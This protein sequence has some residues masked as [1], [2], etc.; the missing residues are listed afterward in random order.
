MKKDG[1][2]R[3]F[4]RW[5]PGYRPSYMGL[6]PADTRVDPELFP[7]NEFPVV[8]PKCDYLL[9]GLP[10][11]TCPECG[12]SFDRGRLLVEQYVIKHG[13]QHAGKLK[14]HFTVLLP[15]GIILYLLAK[16]CFFLWHWLWSKNITLVAIPPRPPLFAFFILLAAGQVCLVLYLVMDLRRVRR[17]RKKVKLVSEAIDKSLPGFQ[18]A[19]RTTK[20]LKVLSLV[21][22]SLYALWAVE[23]RF[24][25][26]HPMQTIVPLIALLGIGLSVWWIGRK[27]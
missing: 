4:L 2:Q 9:R 14:P 5:W 8:C 27:K 19:Q 15:A 20:V 25:W 10:G 12:S 21:S 26:R 6:I 17:N 16:S 11:N 22:V 1:K 7:E 3:R 23:W 24:L 13:R 18:K